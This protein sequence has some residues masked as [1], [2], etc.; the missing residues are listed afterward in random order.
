MLDDMRQSDVE[1]SLPF[2][3]ARVVKHVDTVE[4]PWRAI[5]GAVS[6]SGHISVLGEEVENET[7]Y[8]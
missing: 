1:L 6:I 2:Q 5:A 8:T 4:Q 7:R 3:Y